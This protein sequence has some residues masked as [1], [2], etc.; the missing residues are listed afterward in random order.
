MSLKAQSGQGQTAVIL[1]PAPVAQRLHLL[2]MSVFVSIKFGSHRV[3]FSIQTV[4][5]QVP[6]LKL[7]LFAPSL[8]NLLRQ[9]CAEI[10]ISNTLCL[11]IS[12]INN[13]DSRFCF[14]GTA[15]IFLHPFPQAMPGTEYKHM[16]ETL[17]HV[18]YLKFRVVN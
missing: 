11:V 10:I 7:R 17:C 14:Y 15:Q 2:C 16:S 4:M 3:C 12:R 6:D 13:S 9:L 8:H 18:I 5:L 1:N